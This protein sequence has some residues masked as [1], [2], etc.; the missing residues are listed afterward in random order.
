MRGRFITLEGVDGAGKT[1]HAQWIVEKLEAL[2]APVTATREPGGTPLGEQIR[3]L[4][5]KE[6]MHLHSETLLVFAARSEHIHQVIEPALAKGQ[7]VVCDRY[8][9]ATYAYQGGGRALGPAPIEALEQWIQPAPR[10]DRTFLFDVPLAVARQRL[11]R[12]RDRDRF[13]QE[14]AAF[15]ERTRRAYLQR[16]AQ[17]PQRLCI[18]DSNRP[19]DATRNQLERELTAMVQDWRRGAATS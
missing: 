17:D 1:T 10:P 11:N 5:L 15:F 12:G 9:D 2:G 4:L 3:N 18:I 7:W 14:G 16:A 19:I 8:T 13:E 6:A